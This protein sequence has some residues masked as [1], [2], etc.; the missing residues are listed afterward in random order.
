M[1]FG[2]MVEQ[3]DSLL[4]EALEEGSWRQFPWMRVY[5]WLQVT[6]SDP[7]LQAMHPSEQG[8]HLDEV[9]LTKYPYW[10]VRHPVLLQFRQSG[11]ISPHRRQDSSG[12][13]C[14]IP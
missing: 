12:V 4:L 6:H 7:E 9:K 14:T 11:K 10:Q 3:L 2:K 5:L 1:Q 8:E 13:C